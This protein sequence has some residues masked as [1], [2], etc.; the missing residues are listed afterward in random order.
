MA[1][2]GAT[3]I[4][5][6]RVFICKYPDGYSDQHVNEV[7]EL[8]PA[9]VYFSHLYCPFPGE[10]QTYLPCQTP[11][12]AHL[13]PEIKH[14]WL[15]FFAS[16]LFISS[17]ILQLELF[18]EPLRRG[19]NTIIHSLGL[20][21]LALSRRLLATGLSTDDFGDGVGPL[22]GSDALVREVL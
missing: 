22:L 11:S 2:R 19:L 17:T 14:L 8:W 15:C 4:C 13:A 6:Y 9:S 10:Y 16:H 12:Y 18:I 7:W 20:G 1:P 3:N 21:T 5:R